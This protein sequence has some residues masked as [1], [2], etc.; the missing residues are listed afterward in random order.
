MPDL[1]FQV[2]APTPSHHLNPGGAEVIFRRR[3]LVRFPHS[4][5][6]FGRVSTSCNTLRIVLRI[7]LRSAYAKHFQRILRR[8][9]VA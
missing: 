7:C 6:R 5:F 4:Y 3:H 8:T 2:G 1:V 9:K